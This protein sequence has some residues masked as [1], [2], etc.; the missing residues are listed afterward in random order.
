MTETVATL[1]VRVKKLEADTA[2]LFGKVNDA[3][4]TQAGI[5]EKL[6][7]MLTTLGEVKQA[8]TGLQQAPARRLDGIVRAIITGLVSLAV[9]YLMAK[10]T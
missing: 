8:V 5:N 6:A 10:Y 2:E 7:S 9:G 3:R 1:A 4:E